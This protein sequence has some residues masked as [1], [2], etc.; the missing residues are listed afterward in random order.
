M[1]VPD[2]PAHHS[3]YHTEIPVY[4]AVVQTKIVHLTAWN[5]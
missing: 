1:G 4:Y 5:T 3:N 2:T